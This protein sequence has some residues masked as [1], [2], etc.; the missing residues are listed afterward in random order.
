MNPKQNLKEIFAHSCILQHYSQQPR[1][2]SNPIGHQQ[3][4]KLKKNVV[5]NRM[6]AYNRM[7]CATEYLFFKKEE[8][9]VTQYNME[10]P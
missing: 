1:S 8:N 4:N 3:M 5:Y 10:E 6:G 2:G 9:P 7:Y